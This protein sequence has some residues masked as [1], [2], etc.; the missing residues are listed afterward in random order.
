[1]D[2]WLSTVLAILNNDAVIIH[3]QVLAKIYIVSSLG[4]L[5]RSR[6]SGS[7]GNSGFWGT[8]FS[9]VAASFYIPTSR[10]QA[11]QFLYILINTVILIKT[12]PVGMK[13]YFIVVSICI[14]LMVNDVEHPL[15]C[16]V[17]HLYIFFEEMYI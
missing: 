5:P 9:E 13:W 14:S 16:F 15:V 11:F 17:S 8:Q 12:I 3:V 4:Y 2:I 10:V 1:M 6:I 7:C